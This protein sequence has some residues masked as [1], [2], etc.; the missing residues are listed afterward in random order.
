MHNSITN[1]D[2]ID[3]IM[4]IQYYKTYYITFKVPNNDYI[5]KEYDWPSMSD[6]GHTIW[7]LC[8]DDMTI[9]PNDYLLEFKIITDNLI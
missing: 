9:I 4:S 6:E 1:R 5:Y 3:L 2:K 8:K 7:T